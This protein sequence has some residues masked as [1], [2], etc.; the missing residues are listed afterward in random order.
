M[1][2]LPGS[3]G[4]NRRS[5]LREALG[6]ANLRSDLREALSDAHG[7]M[8]SAPIARSELFPAWPRLP[9]W[10]RWI[11]KCADDRMFTVTVVIAV[12]TLALVA[13]AILRH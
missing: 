10:R 6:A 3:D 1:T 12:G 2:N 5:E 11:A 7:Q 8:A 9:L 13:L 4:Q